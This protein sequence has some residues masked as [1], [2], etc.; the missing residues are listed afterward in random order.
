LHALDGNAIAGQLLDH[1]GAEMTVVSGICRHCGTSSQIGELRVYSRA[2][3]AVVRCGTCGEIVMVLV[4]IRD[5]LRV[6]F[7]QFSLPR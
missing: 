4:T 6:D 7:S 3:G 2:P 1:F 5:R